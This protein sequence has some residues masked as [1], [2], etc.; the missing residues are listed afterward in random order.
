MY[1][2]FPQP[3]KF[4]R[5]GTITTNGKK[6]PEFLQAMQ[7]DNP[8]ESLFALF[9]D[10][11]ELACCAA[12]AFA[13]EKISPTQLST[14]LQLRTM[15]LEAL[16][17]ELIPIF[18]Q[19]GALTEVA[20]HNLGF[21]SAERLILFSNELKMQPRSEHYL[22]KVKMP[23]IRDRRLF[24]LLLLA[25][26]QGA[27]MFNLPES[28][29]E[30]ETGIDIE[31]TGFLS[32]ALEAN[33]KSKFGKYTKKSFPFPGK[34]SIDDIE[35]SMMNN[36]RPISVAYPG[37]VNSEQFHEINASQYYL[38][39]HDLLHFITISSIPMEIYQ[40][41]LHAINLV[42]KN[43]G[44]KWSKEIWD[45][46]DMDLSL[47]LYDA[48]AHQGFHK[49][50]LRSYFLRAIDG[51]VSTEGRP[52]GLF[53]STALNDTMWLFIIDVLFNGPQWDAI[54]PG[55]QTFT[56]GT[57]YSAYYL[58]AQQHREQLINKSLAQQIVTLKSLWFKTSLP[59]GEPVFTK[60]KRSD[61]NLIQIEID[62]VPFKSAK[63][64]VLAIKTVEIMNETHTT[65]TDQQQRLFE[66]DFF[67]DTNRLRVL[68]LGTTF[69][70]VMALLPLHHK[71]DVI[72]T[73]PARSHLTI[74]HIELIV[75][76]FP[77]HQS[78]IF[79]ALEG[80]FSNV[81]VLAHYIK[82]EDDINRLFIC[83][84]NHHEQMHIYMKNLAKEHPL[85]WSP[86]QNAQAITEYTRPARSVGRGLLRTF[87][88]LSLPSL[89]DELEDE[90]EQNK[91]QFSK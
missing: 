17:L 67:S 5:N 25:R 33:I 20:A 65:L 54:I 89:E 81:Q 51:T 42:R 2:F 88:T 14:L 21:M 90:E 57:P 83:F 43:T 27:V 38:T 45:S 59:N 30:S 78:D 49:E 12:H 36:E 9:T 8:Y 60:T 91:L 3:N 53:S 10:I 23:P 39:L 69:E 80:I 4:F 13:H 29:A 75:N 74:E 70:R 63:K 64:D 24:D 76:T 6:L 16:S 48:I 11:D 46:L 28:E 62:G 79:N 35:R 41:I 15:K 52:F 68:M 86:I 77:H 18:T 47:F 22:Y 85:L 44:I 1:S 61:G 34:L 58:F 32:G 7:E 84:P 19:N 37:I 71:H 72:S 31:I 50:N 66:E 55:L 82:T 26:N 56:Q 87:S 40:G 73:L